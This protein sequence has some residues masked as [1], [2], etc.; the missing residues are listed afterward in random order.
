[1]V[2]AGDVPEV[3]GDLQGTETLLARVEGA[4]IACGAALT[5]DETG[6]GSKISGRRKCHEARPFSPSFLR[7]LGR[8]PELAPFPGRPRRIASARQP[9]GCRGFTGPGPSTP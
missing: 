1:D 9:G 4:E 8:R 3:V 6:R 2:G 7:H 5:A